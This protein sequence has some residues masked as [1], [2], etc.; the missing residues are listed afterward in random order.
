MS[1]G[2]GAFVVPEGGSF[3]TL[4][5]DNRSLN[6]CP[7][8]SFKSNTFAIHKKAVHALHSQSGSFDLPSPGND[9]ELQRVIEELIK[10]KEEADRLKEES[11][12]ASAPTSPP[13]LHG[14]KSRFAPLNRVDSANH[15]PVLA[16]LIGDLSSVSAKDFESAPEFQSQSF[17]QWNAVS[18]SNAGSLPVIGFSAEETVLDAESPV[19]LL[20]DSDSV[21]VK[22]SPP[23]KL[24]V[25]VSRGA[26]CSDSKAFEKGKF[27]VWNVRGKVCIGWYNRF[28]DI[29]QIQCLGS[30]VA[31][32]FTVPQEQQ[33]KAG[34]AEMDD[35][36]QF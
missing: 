28:P 33:Q 24:L 12:S 30:V 19:C 35:G 15:M 5:S 16:P 10:R 27:Y 2:Y 20:A 36:F 25:L 31:V 8:S 4:F 17:G 6:T 3:L 14:E 9:D 18:V 7:S 1:A 32:F 13:L 26:R 22:L 34:F 29:S 11:L 21:G 23:Q